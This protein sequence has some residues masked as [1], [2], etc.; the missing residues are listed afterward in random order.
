MDPV[1]LGVLVGAAALVSVAFLAAV[2]AIWA[3]RKAVA[4]AKRMV[5][6]GVVLAL[7]AGGVALAVALFLASS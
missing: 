6:L 4:L 3:L 7:F 5:L 2:I 1:T